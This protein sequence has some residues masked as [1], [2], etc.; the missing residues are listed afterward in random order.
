MKSK[1]KMKIEKFE[2]DEKN[3]RMKNHRFAKAK[4]N[5]SKKNR[6]KTMNTKRTKELII[7]VFVPVLVIK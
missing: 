6:E 4:V 1:I 5:E 2:Y 3:W 7:E